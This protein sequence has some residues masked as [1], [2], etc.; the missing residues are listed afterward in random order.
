MFAAGYLLWLLQRTA[1]GTPKAEFA[2]DHI[3]DVELPEWLAWM[4]LLVLIVVIGIYPNIVFNV[5]D[6][7]VRSRAAAARRAGLQLV[8]CVGHDVLALH[9]AARRLRTRSR[10]RS[11]SPRRSSV[12]LLVD[13]RVG[14]QPA[15]SSASLAG[16]R[17]ARR[18]GAGAHL[19]VD[20][21]DRF[22]FGG[23]PATSS[24]TSR[25]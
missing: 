22:V 3:H 5:T 15:R 10:P 25:S 16:H 20:G 11:S 2:D 14:A 8:R 24:T 7:G 13:V 23:N 1:F 4:P 17:P 12:M 18:A 6:G 9:R 21:A 19:A